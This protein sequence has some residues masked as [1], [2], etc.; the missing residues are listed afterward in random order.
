MREV[1]DQSSDGED[2][3]SVLTPNSSSQSP[4]H[5]NF[6][7]FV[8]DILQDIRNSLQHPNRSQILSLYSSFMT[9]VDP[10]VKLLHG[11]SLF[12]YLVQ[13]AEE[14]ACSPGPKG[15]EALKFAIY[16]TTTTSLTPNECLQQLG[17]DKMVLLPRYRTSTELALAKADFIN[18]EDMS[19]LQALVLYLVSLSFEIFL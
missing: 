19:T 1:L 13:E 10:T 11:P 3:D 8:P 5:S 2:E 14:I 18:T 7:I 4:G 9:N 6:V 16:Y 17:E 12:R 15:W